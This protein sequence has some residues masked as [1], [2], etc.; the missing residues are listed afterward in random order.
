[1]LCN[2]KSK[3]GQGIHKQ[4]LSRLSK[5]FAWTKMSQNLDGEGFVLLTVRFWLELYQK[6]FG[7]HNAFSVL[8]RPLNFEKA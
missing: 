3:V 7:S 1:M 2:L 4:R 6:P 5:L 8:I